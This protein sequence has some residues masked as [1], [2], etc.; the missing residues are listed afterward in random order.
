MKSLILRFRALVLGLAT[1][2][3][4][5]PMALSAEHASDLKPI[6]EADMRKIEAAVPTTAIVP[7]KK[8]RKLL[9][10][11]RNVGYGGHPSA[12]YANHA[13]RLMGEKT[14][15]FEAV[16]SRD[17]EIFRRDHL[18]QFDAVFFNNDVGN[19]FTDP[20]LATQPG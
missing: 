15:A 16:V 5:Q 2:S 19:L 3:L 10:F 20:E 6:P 11:V 7:P 12:E 18:A 1:F 9:L 4:G 13:F 14:G 17:P 8:P